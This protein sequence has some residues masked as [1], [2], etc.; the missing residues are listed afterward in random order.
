[1]PTPETA[2]RATPR[3]PWR[4]PAALAWCVAALAVAV[5]VVYL[6][7]AADDPAATEP[8]VDAHT[9]H[10]LARALVEDGRFDARFLWQATFYPF[11][12]AAVYKLAG[13]SVL[14][15]KLVQAVL[16]G[17]TCLLTVRLGRRLHGDAAGLLAGLVVALYGP[18]V[19][20]ESQLLATGW[21]AFWSI[22]LA[23]LATEYS[24]RPR[25]RTG[26]VFGLAGALAILTRPTFVPVAVALAAWLALDLRR[27]EARPVQWR[28]LLGALLA[29]AVLLVPYGLAM[30]SLTGHAGVV[31]PSGGINLMV[32]NNPDYERTI[33]IRPGLAWE[34]LVA[35][36][37]RQG[38]GPDPWNGQEYF[39]GE[40]RGFVR[41]QPAAAAGLLGRKALQ[42]VSSRELPR[43]HDV[44]LHRDWSRLLEFTV[45]R[46]GA[47]GFPFGVLL[48]LTVLGL[49][50]GGVRGSGPLLVVV[51][52]FALSL[53]AVFVSARYRTPLVPL[54]AIPAGHG[55]VAG[56]RLLGEP[57]VR[58]L[59]TAAG[60]V[61]AVG[62]LGTLPGPFAQ[63]DVDLAAEVHY[64]VG[65]NRYQR[66]DWEGAA[67]HLAR[68]V[69]LDPT[70]PEARNFLGI[71]LA[72]LGR[73][74][75]AE[76]HFVAAVRLKPDYAE[77]ANN[78]QVCR[79][80]LADVLYRRALAVES[81][82][83]AAS[84]RDLVRATELAPGWPDPAARLAWIRATSSRDSLRDGAAALL[85]VRSRPLRDHGDDPWLRLVEAAALAE[86]GR[87]DEA[88]A[89]AERARDAASGDTALVETI[90]AALAAFRDRRPWRAEP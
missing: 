18:L 80:R 35:M 11:F 55:L 53:V 66:E 85:L 32:G 30:R 31:P 75:E 6:L 28:G 71:T 74:E 88:V 29:A 59:L 33:N 61:L 13:V 14:A 63:E 23:A 51:A 22:A 26:L 24:A 79:R 8:L 86:L 4:A 67:E 43:N 78:L 17:F 73:L 58:P 90:D 7:D 83:P 16:A 1:M 60:L 3:T 65:W 12:L 62:V 34:E 87:Y 56:W 36:P 10:E 42:F 84:V 25:L 21:T 39:L 19:F 72:N 57:R 27:H 54:L 64:G 89:Q 82:N 37:Q 45:F 48:P 47:W 76:S 2:P 68:A 15:A 5:R 77:A 69:E 70:L 81:G 46:I 41:T 49:A 20:F 52:V 50:R 44:Y 40:V 9:Y 38:Y